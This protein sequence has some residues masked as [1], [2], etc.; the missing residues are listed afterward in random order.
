MENS[1]TRKMPN[2]LPLMVLSESF[3]CMAESYWLKYVW[4]K[5]MN[6][7]YQIYS[8]PKAKFADIDLAIHCTIE[9]RTW[10]MSDCQNHISSTKPKI[11]LKQL[12]AT[13]P[14]RYILNVDG[15]HIFNENT[16][17]ALSRLRQDKI[18]KCSI[19]NKFCLRLKPLLNIT[20]CKYNN[21]AGLICL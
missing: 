2:I 1:R 7:K 14:W 8:P 15:Q 17:F 21:L 19:Q 3:Y 12:F 9:H 13:V 6:I 4:N 11:N 16:K 20:A 5:L 10:Y 18:L